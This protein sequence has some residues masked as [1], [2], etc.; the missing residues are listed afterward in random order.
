M[1]S[2]QEAVSYPI[3]GR[4]R[5]FKHLPRR[6]PAAVQHQRRPVPAVEPQHRPRLVPASLLHSSPPSPLL[7][8]PTHVP[9]DQLRAWNMQLN[10]ACSNLWVGYYICVG[11]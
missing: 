7:P 3:S 10:D 8:N 11:V 2:R 6:Q 4:S 1:G 5:P 9:L